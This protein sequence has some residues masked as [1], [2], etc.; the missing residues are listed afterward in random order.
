MKILYVASECAPF[1]ASGGLGDVIGA[2][3]KFVKAERKNDVVEVIIPLYRALD[4]KYKSRLRYVCDLEFSLSWRKTGA[5]VYKLREDNVNYYFIDNSYYFDR[6]RLYGEY[7]D[8]ERFAFF[9][10][11]VVAFIKAQPTPPNVVH[12]ND[13]QTAPFVIYLKTVFASDLKLSEVKTLYTIHNIEYQGKFSLDIL[14]DV[15]G[16]EDSYRG[17]LEYDNCINLMKGAIIC[18][19]YV[20]TVS[21]NYANELKYDFFACGLSGII[22]SVSEKMCGVVNGIDYTQFSPEC[23]GDIYEPYSYESLIEGKRKNKLALEEELGL[24]PDE[25]K[26]LLVMITR[27]TEGK[28]IDLILHILDEL[29]SLDLRLVVLGTGEERYEASLI[30]AE[31]KHKNL[32]ALIK[33][34]RALSKK[35]Y[36]AAD[37]FLMPSKSEPCGLAQMIATSYGT[38]PLVRSVGGLYD[39][40][41]PYG[42]SGANGFRFD[43]YNAHELLYCVKYALSV[44]NDKEKWAQLCHSAKESDFSWNNSAKKYISIYKNIAKRKAK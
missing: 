10:M 36:A 15:F 4:E 1:A 33:F 41:I 23:G 14:G 2:L 18:S 7:D 28:G 39:T 5:S 13:W 35:M 16:I 11:A 21:P 3:P 24:V 42:F 37:I 44:Y 27:L 29:L 9:C 34:D 32:K 25:S 31:K 30:E 19:D 8:A 12:A 22:S 43:E 20:N 38:V 17:V 26:A 6:D 40:I